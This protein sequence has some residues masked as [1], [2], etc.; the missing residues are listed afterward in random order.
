MFGMAIEDGAVTANPVRASSARISVGKKS[1]RALT[2]E[3][4]ARLVGWMRASERAVALDIPDLVDWMLATGCCIGEALALRHGPNVDGKP[5]L[6]LEANTW[7]INATVVR[8][9][10]QGLLVQRRP[11]TA[12]GLARG[13]STRLRYSDGADA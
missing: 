7:E 9:P 8:V 12:A 5:L 3:E 10:K 6:D 11:K 13:R 4:A 1:P 2:P